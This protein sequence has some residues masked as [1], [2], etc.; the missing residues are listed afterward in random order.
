MLCREVS[1]HYEHNH[2]PASLKASATSGKLLRPMLMLAV[3]DMC[4]GELEAV[5]PAAAALEL[6]HV[7]SLIHDDIIDRDELR[8]GRPTLH[9][10]VGAEQAIV[11]AD[12]L[13]FTSFAWGDAATAR[14]AA[15]GAVARA[16]SVMSHDFTAM[17]RGELLQGELC[18]SGRETLDDYRRMIA[19]KTGAL[20]ACSASCGAVLSGADEQTIARFR[21]LGSRIGELLQYLDD[22]LLFSPEDAPDGKNKTSDIL[23]GRITLPYLIAVESLPPDVVSELRTQRALAASGAPVD[24]GT[25][26][27]LLDNPTVRSRAVD[28]VAD[29]AKSCHEILE[30]APRTAGWSFTQNLVSTLMESSVAY[31]Q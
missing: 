6:C 25:V 7:G 1:H 27:S 14:G 24:A 4:G 11:V 10:V 15:D 9:T 29:M 8:R 28:L 31:A 13:F 17:C 3:C 5:L 20:F 26:Y 23:N 12:S 30:T 16:L 18:R 22:L 2:L 19:L 21:I